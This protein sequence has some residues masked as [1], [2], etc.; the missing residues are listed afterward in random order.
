M[1]FV[2]KWKNNNVNKIFNKVSF[3]IYFNNKL[4]YSKYME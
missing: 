2:L 4:D 1:E 3:L